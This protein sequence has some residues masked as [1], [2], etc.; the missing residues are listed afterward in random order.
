MK[1]SKGSKKTYVILDSD[2]GE[3]RYAY[4]LQD[5]KDHID[6]MSGNFTDLQSFSEF[7]DE[8]IRVFE[9]GRKLKIKIPSEKITVS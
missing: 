8:N 3:Y 9:I 4:S 2:C 5:V 1:N 6:N 7:V